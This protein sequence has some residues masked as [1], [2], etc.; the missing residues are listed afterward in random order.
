MPCTYKKTEFL[1]SLF[2]RIEGLEKY[3]D[4]VSG[5]KNKNNSSAEM[6]SNCTYYWN[7]FQQN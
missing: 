5:N 2:R 1:R 7:Q 6:L 3:G 4:S